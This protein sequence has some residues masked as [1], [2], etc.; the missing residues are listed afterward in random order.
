[1]FDLVQNIVGD[2]FVQV[3]GI[4]F[5]CDFV[6]LIESKRRDHSDSI[7]RFYEF[8]GQSN[9]LLNF[10]KKGNFELLLIVDHSARQYPHI[11]ED[12]KMIRS[13]CDEQIFVFV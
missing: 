5:Y 6:G 4:K 3:K 13:F 10:S 11:W 12:F 7:G 9:F 8:E 2:T 1:M